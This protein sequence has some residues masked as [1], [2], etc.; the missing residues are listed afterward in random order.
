[1]YEVRQLGGDDGSMNRIWGT[2][3][4]M[5]FSMTDLERVVRVSRR[6]ALL[7]LQIALKGVPVVAQC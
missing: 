7:C 6:E 3:G 1:M 2:L 4:L 5:L